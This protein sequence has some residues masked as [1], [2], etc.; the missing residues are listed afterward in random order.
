ML[1][2]HSCKYTI[3][4]LFTLKTVINISFVICDVTLMMKDISIAGLD[5][6]VIYVFSF[7]Y[8]YQFL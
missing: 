4:S 2:Y 6:E 8:R 3:A 5:L 1:M 7:I